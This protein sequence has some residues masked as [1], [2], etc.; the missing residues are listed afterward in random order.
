MKTAFLLHLQYQ[1]LY[2]FAQEKILKYLLCHT[3]YYIL[4]LTV[5]LLLLYCT[6]LET[7]N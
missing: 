5:Q 4:L 7:G 2:F 3:Y 6:I 1:F